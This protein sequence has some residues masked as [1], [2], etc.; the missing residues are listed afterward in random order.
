MTSVASKLGRKLRLGGAITALVLTMLVGATNA[1]AMEGSFSGHLA[2]K[3]WTTNGAFG[4]INILYG[5]SNTPGLTL[6]I[7]PA[8]YSGSWS[9]PWGWTCT[10]SPVVGVGG[11]NAY[12]AADNPNSREM[13]FSVG[14]Y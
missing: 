2:G 9:F 14:Y 13:S 6:C 1:Q 12:P 11:A 10:N 8:E 5:S 4:S 7:A 3:T